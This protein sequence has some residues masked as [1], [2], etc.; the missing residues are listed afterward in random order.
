MSLGHHFQSSVERV[1]LQVVYYLP[2]DPGQAPIRLRPELLGGEERVLEHKG[3]LNSFAHQFDDHSDQEDPRLQE[4]YQKIMSA[5]QGIVRIHDR[6][7]RISSLL[8]EAA[9]INPDNTMPY[10]D[11]LQIAPKIIVPKPE[12]L[13]STGMGEENTVFKTL[14]PYPRVRAFLQFWQNEIEGPM[15]HIRIAAGRAATSTYNNTH[16]FHVN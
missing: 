12:E 5:S 10:Q 6:R 1:S 15:H 9:K 2:L 7:E 3:I 8:E 13:T 14:I 4:A 16:H 11:A